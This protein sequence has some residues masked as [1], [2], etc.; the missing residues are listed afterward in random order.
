MSWTGNRRA[1]FI[2]LRGRALDTIQR[3]AT[4]VIAAPYARRPSALGIGRTIE[5]LIEETDDEQKVNA[6]RLL[7]TTQRRLDVFARVLD[8]AARCGSALEDGAWGR[9]WARFRDGGARYAKAA[10]EVM[11]PLRPF[12]GAN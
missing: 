5:G 6:E 11:L 1:S 9:A 12:Y 7:Q 10:S 4:A 8:A 2:D 3:A